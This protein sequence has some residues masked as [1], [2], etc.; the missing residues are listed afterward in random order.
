MVPQGLC[1]GEGI[2][3]AAANGSGAEVQVSQ[4]M[5]PDL[6]LG[7]HNASTPLPFAKPLMVAYPPVIHDGQTG[8]VGIHTE[9]ALPSQHVVALT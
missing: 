7:H 4:G 3:T 2:F 8:D 5:G 6:T 9:T 1:V